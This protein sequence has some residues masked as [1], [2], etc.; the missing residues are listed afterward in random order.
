MRPET[1]SE[2]LVLQVMAAQMPL[3]GINSV[4]HLGSDTLS[5]VPNPT[6]P[7]PTMAPWAVPLLKVTVF[8]DGAL[9]DVV[10]PVPVLPAAPPPV[11]PVGTTVPGGVPQ[12]SLP[13]LCRVILSL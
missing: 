13:P 12:I 2:S 5:F 4:P 6:Q 1:H 11:P 10:P 7:T 3:G 9:L 8:P